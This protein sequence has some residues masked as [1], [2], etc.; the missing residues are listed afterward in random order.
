M[1]LTKKIILGITCFVVF[2][3]LINF[4]L[5]L[6]LTNRLPIVIKENNTTP[7]N[8][9]YDELKVDLFPSNIYLTNLVVSPKVKPQ[10]S[11]AKT[12]VYG[13]TKSITIANFSI[14]KFIFSNVIKAENITIN[15]PNI[16]L[17]QKEKNAK[18]FQKKISE[19]F[20]KLILVSN[21]YLKKGKLAIVSTEDNK[22]ILSTQNITSNL[23]G[24]AVNDAILDNKIPFLFKKYRISCDSLFYQPNEFYTIKAQ[25]IQSSEHNLQIKKLEYLPEYTRAQFIQKIP[26]EKDIF[27]IKAS[28]ININSMEWGFKNDV[29][30]FDAK[31]IVLDK[32][33][34]NI[35]RNKIPEDDLSKKP[36]YSALL[37]KIKFPLKVDTLLISNSKLVYEEEINFEKGPAKLTFDNFNLNAAHIQ[38][39]FQ[40]KKADDINIKID[41]R[42]MKDSPLK[43]H[44]TFN[45]LDLND[46]FRI[47]GNIKNFD[48]KSLTQFT[49]PY[50]NASFDGVFDSYNFD[51][52]GND[53]NAYGNASLKF[54][55]LDVTFYKKNDRDQEAKLKSGVVK[56][57]LKKNSDNKSKEA[58]IELE[59]IQE[60]SFYN[61]LWRSIAES[62]KKILI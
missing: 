62:L 12:G 59:R 4:G 22:I 24:I 41:C 33:D 25:N 3:F 52:K 18:N 39:G 61:F 1:S 9:N 26:K 19:P 6:W 20:E 44:W 35:Y 51:I 40:L 58:A 48:I 34:A 42:F 36:L 30:F 55:D 13:N 31:S 32:V 43:V 28:L 57:F 21:I 53:K 27:S 49:K 50:I 56:L 7:Y 38:S 29:F 11:D 37:R 14:W 16:I 5:N 47:K 15:E 10:K 8:F 46:S 60:K 45:V 2:I 23:E 17:Y 54:K